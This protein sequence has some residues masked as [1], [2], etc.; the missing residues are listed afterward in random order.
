MN[1]FIERLKERPEHHRRRYTFALSAFFSAF[2]FIIWASV[3][4]PSDVKHVA[5]EKTSKPEA[6][7]PV[8]VLKS[9][10]ASVYDAAKSLFSDTETK[11][12]DFETEY[13]KMKSQVESG[14]VKI[15]PEPKR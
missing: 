15:I 11:K 8:S 7:T 10:V 5:I 6:E 1:N 9:S 12:I 13:E 3:I 2:I 14:Q 4:L